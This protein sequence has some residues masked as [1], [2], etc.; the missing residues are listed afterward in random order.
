MAPDA[1][2]TAS[3]RPLTVVAI[4][5]GLLTFYAGLAVVG[6]RQICRHDTT[7]I[8]GSKPA[9]QPV[10]TARLVHLVKLPVTPSAP[11]R[12]AHAMHDR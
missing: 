4:L 8:C 12:P 7:N 3:P 5:V 1:E 2:S 9:P 10:V 6:Y 11:V